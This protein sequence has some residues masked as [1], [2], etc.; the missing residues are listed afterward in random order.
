MI[1][2]FV[3]AYYIHNN[4]NLDIRTLKK[5]K[6]FIYDKVGVKPFLKYNSFGADNFENI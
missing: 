4:F 5:D 3:M 1:P 6:E 2:L